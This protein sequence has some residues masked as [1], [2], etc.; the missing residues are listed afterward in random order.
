MQP[1]QGSVTWWIQELKEGDRDAARKLWERYF[2]QLLAFI[3]KKFKNFPRRMSD[4][5]DVVLQAFNSFFHKV[6]DGRFPALDDRDS[7]WR[8]LIV[9]GSQKAIDCMRIENALK[10]QQIELQPRLEPSHEELTMMA[11]LWERL[12]HSLGADAQGQALQ[13]IAIWKMENYTNAEI[14]AKLD[15][16]ERTV[17]RKLELIRKTWEQ[18]ITHE[19]GV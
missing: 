10:R 5:E 9:M 8:L 17:E 1:S 7:L 12:M 19:F 16:T 2:Q 13:Q 18:Q 14:A 15:V 3:R 4:E 6:E 11:D